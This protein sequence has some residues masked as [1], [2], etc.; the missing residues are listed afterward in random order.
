M[1]IGETSVSKYMVRSRR[2]PSQTWRTFLENHVKGLVSVDF[3]TVQAM[4]SAARRPEGFVRSNRCEGAQTRDAPSGLEDRFGG[5]VG[6]ARQVISIRILSFTG[7]RKFC[8]QPV[9]LDG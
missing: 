7:W 6:P 3:F 8:L 5:R 9:P 2:P 1:D 4:A